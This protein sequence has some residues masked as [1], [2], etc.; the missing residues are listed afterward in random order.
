[1]SVRIKFC[2]ITR[3]EDAQAAAKLGADALGFVF[4]A[5]SPRCVGVAQ[6]AAIARE[7]PPFVSKVGLFVNAAADEVEDVCRAVGLDVVQYHGDESPE[8]CAQA[9]KP[10]IKAIRVRPELDIVA[11]CRRYAQAS[12][13]LFDTYDDK[14]Y[15]GSGKAFDWAL[16][17]Q[18]H[19]RPI[20]LAGG[21]TPDNVGQ[22]I[23]STAPYAVDV[24][25][26]IEA[27]KGIKDHDKMRKFIAEVQRCEC[28]TR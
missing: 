6:A 3:A 27:A 5:P 1:M 13:W 10:W 26:G 18:Q 15:G 17:P 25:G 2:G 11:E 20:I 24:S 9:P 8:H 21:L 16:L 4:Y 22:A 7:L 28:E 12:A 19:R 23:R 14:L